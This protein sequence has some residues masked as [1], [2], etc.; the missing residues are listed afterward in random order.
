MGANQSAPG[1][2]GTETG[3]LGGANAGIKT[4]YYE[5]LGID[6]HASEDEIKK[7]YR[8]KALE[9]HPDRNY[10][11]IENSTKLFA[12]VQSAYEVLSDLQERAWYDSHR[13]TLLRTEGGPTTEHYE[14]NVRVTTAEDILGMFVRLNGRLDYSDSPSGFYNTIRDSFDALAREEQLTRDWEGLDQI[15]YPTFGSAKDSYEDIARPFYAFWGGFAT[16]KSFSW[17]DVY[18]YSEAPD[19]RVRRMMEKENKRLRDEG[20]REFN[21]A[22]RSLVTFVRKRDPRYIPYS[23]TEADRQKT[24][25]DAAA[26]QAARS[27]ASNQAK[28][29]EQVVPDWTN[30]ETAADHADTEE[31]AEEEHEHFECVVCKKIFKSEKQYEAHEKSKKHIKAV[32]QIRKEM[33]MEVGRFGLNDAVVEIPGLAALENDLSDINFADTPVN[34]DRRTPSVSKNTPAEPTEPSEESVGSKRHSQETARMQ[35]LHLPSD[36]GLLVEDA[37]LSESNDDYASREHIQGRI[38]GQCEAVPLSSRHPLV[39]QSD[40]NASQDPGLISPA[41]ED[42]SNSRPKL[43]KAKMKRAKKAAKQSILVEDSPQA[44]LCV[45]CQAGFPSK[46]RL[47]N[48]IK[49]FGHAQPVPGNGKGAAKLGKC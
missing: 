17:K 37:E 40:F 43:G 15:E 13:D 7:A 20:I 12:E 11:N 30:V 23:Q 35:H 22:V 10:G 4:C 41:E 31:E 21:D 29:E 3:G 42:S 14:H 49:D 46:T 24:L 48:H 16:K 5:L 6:R 33:K 26:A 39:G 25:R 36:D 32:Q 44:Y 38:L 27:R 19:R 8:R 47:F 1:S 28:L 9:L 18:R 34:V 2:G 45:T